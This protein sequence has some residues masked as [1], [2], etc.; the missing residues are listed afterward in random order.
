M[1][2]PVDL[3]KPAFSADPVPALARSV[4][5]L[6]SES[7]AGVRFPDMD[8]TMLE[9][10]ADD[11]RAAQVEIEQIEAEL[12]AARATLQGQADQLLQRAQ[13]AL[14]YARIFAESDPTLAARVQQVGEAQRP[15]AGSSVPKRRGRPAKREEAADSSLFELGDAAV[16]GTC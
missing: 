11:L 6:F 10:A 4:I 8:L 16:E 3:P 2:S 5:A 13:R 15:A 1:S 9:S 7:L 14:A 12:A